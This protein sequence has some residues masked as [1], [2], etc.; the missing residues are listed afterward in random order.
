M[1]TMAARRFIPNFLPQE[2]YGVS[3]YKYTGTGQEQV[4]I[5]L[6][7]QYKQENTAASVGGVAL[8]QPL[9]ASALPNKGQVVDYGVP[10]FVDSGAFAPS[11][12]SK[13]ALQFLKKRTGK[14]IN[15]K[16][17]D[18]F[19]KARMGDQS[20][21]LMGFYKGQLPGEMPNQRTVFI[22]QDSPAGLGTL[23]HEAGHAVDANLKQQHKIQNNFNPAYINSLSKPAARLNYLFETTGFPKVVSE[24]EAQRFA[25][26]NLNEFQK[27]QQNNNK[28]TFDSKIFTDSPDYKFYPGSF[29]GRAVN[30]FFETEL[31]GNR[32]LQQP[33]NSGSDTYDYNATGAA[34][35][36]PPTAQKGVAFGTDPDLWRTQERIMQKTRDYVDPRLDQY[37][38]NPTPALENFWS[39]R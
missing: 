9:P 39:P 2:A 13:D 37:M 27:Q 14:E 20:D 5:P 35:F 11:T 34:V 1:L 7:L 3:P 23:F 30:R 31:P 38:T 10:S 17:I 24:T 36:T 22:N 16:P 12:L 4:D 32:P 28:T 15:I 18:V 19:E 26:E 33:L 25:G 21:G 8:G 29:A 6:G